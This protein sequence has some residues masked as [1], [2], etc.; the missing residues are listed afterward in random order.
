[1][2]TGLGALAS[3]AGAGL[4][5]AHGSDALAASPGQAEP[6]GLNDPDGLSDAAEPAGLDVGPLLSSAV[7][8]SS[9]S[10]LLCA[11]ICTTSSSPASLNTTEQYRLPVGRRKMREL[12]G[13]AHSP[14]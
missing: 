9:S 10:R 5:A 2:N 7:W 3:S 11:P 14:C 13:H 4:A 6:D 1:M 8:P 12:A